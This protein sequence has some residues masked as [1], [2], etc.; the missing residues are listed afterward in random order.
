M[1]STAENAKF[2]E[3]IFN[4]FFAVSKHEFIEF[5]VLCTPERKARP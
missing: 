5:L 2:A 1:I 3:H 4:A